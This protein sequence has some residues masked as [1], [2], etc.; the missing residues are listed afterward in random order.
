MHK[1]GFIR[2]SPII[3]SYNDQVQMLNIVTDVEYQVLLEP[4]Y[5]IITVSILGIICYY[6]KRTTLGPIACLSKQIS[7]PFGACVHYLASFSGL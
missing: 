5:N 7:C 3:V 6:L 1:V 2:T 4:R